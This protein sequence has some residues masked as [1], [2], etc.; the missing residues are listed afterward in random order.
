[1]F[2]N[3]FFVAI[4]L[5]VLFSLSSILLNY[6]FDIITKCFP[7]FDLFVSLKTV[8]RAFDKLVEANQEAYENVKNKFLKKRAKISEWDGIL[9]IQK[10]SLS[11]KLFN[12]W[13]SGAPFE[14]LSAFAT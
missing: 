3:N 8:S 6:S 5:G 2:F 14:V 10:L 12:R 7:R 4:V 13:I 1:M 11:K 9:G